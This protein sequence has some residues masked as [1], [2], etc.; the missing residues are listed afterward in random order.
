MTSNEDGYVKD[1]AQAACLLP[2]HVSLP[3]PDAAVQPC[4]LATV[5]CSAA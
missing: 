3:L 2:G 5:A 4:G 1:G